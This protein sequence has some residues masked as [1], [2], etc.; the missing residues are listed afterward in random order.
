MAMPLHRGTLLQNAATTGNGTAIDLG[1]QNRE[2]AVYIIGSSGITAGAVTVETADVTDYSGT[3]ATLAGPVTLAAST[4]N[5]VQVSG[6]LAALRAR[7]STTVTGGTVT[8]RLWV[9]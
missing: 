4:Q 3:W 9:D 1:G 7:I 6:V 8:V 5:V 2:A